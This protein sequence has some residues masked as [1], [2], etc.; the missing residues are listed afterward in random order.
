MSVAN[1]SRHLQELKAARLL[2]V[3]RQGLYAFYRLADPGVF[4]AWQAIRDLAETRLGD[5][6]RLV[7]VHLGH[8]ADIETI[9]PDVLAHRMRAGDVVVL[10][11]RPEGEYRAGH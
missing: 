11:V 6:D 3:R 10:D 7:R 5:I 8:R 1:T 2:A 9:A 4:R